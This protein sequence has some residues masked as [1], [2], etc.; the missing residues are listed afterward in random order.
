MKP[1]QYNLYIPTR[2]GYILY[3]TLHDSILKADAEL[4]EI[5][6]SNIDALD[7]EHIHVLKTMGMVVDNDVDETT[8]VSFRYN[9]EKYSS[10]YSMFVI[11]P[12]LACNLACK[13]CYER[14]SDLPQKTMDDKTV[15]DTILF[16]KRMAIEDN[17]KTILIKLYGGEPLLNVAACHTIV[18][19]VSAW[20]KQVFM[21]V[22]VVLQTNGTLLSDE[23]L[24]T[25]GPYLTYVELTIDGPQ[26]VHDKTRVYK[27]GKGTYNDI[28]KAIERAVKR[29][30]HTILRINVKNAQN[31]RDVLS[32]LTERGFKGKREV[33]FYYA[34]TSEFGLCELFTNKQLCHADEEKALDM[35]P[36]LRTAIK[37]AGWMD[38]LETPDVIQ[39]QKFV[40]CNNEKK[41]RYVI[42]PDGD[43][44]LCFFRAGQKEYKAGTIKEGGVFG[45]LYYEMLARTP[46]Q[47]A[48]CHSCV[49]LPLCGGGCA[50]RALEQSKTF[51]TNNCGSVKDFAAKRILMY[52]KRKYPERFGEVLP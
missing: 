15:A 34:Q 6:E 14:S 48:E 41:G 20:A 43:I 26:A 50:M 10:P 31:L 12:T 7:K 8:I 47:F 52:L 27:T 28:M 29:G 38:Q 16:I 32:D 44:Y 36:G 30:V 35:S 49:Y 13:Y 42:D 45:P 5:L 51:H 9:K 17:A 18:N 1:S 40:S 19:E 23:V 21:Q 46:L 25:L 2:D 22:A 37:D 24:D 4:K 11:L 3:N 39:K 33:K